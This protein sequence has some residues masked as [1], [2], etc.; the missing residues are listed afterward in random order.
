MVQERD[1]VYARW[2]LSAAGVDSWPEPRD[3][4]DEQKVIADVLA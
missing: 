1:L 2:I 3:E 4:R